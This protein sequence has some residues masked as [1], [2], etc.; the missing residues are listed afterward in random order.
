MYFEKD[1]RYTV[2]YTLQDGT[3]F[4]GGKGYVMK[5]DIGLEVVT[6]YGVSKEERQNEETYLNN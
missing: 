6:K 3:V 1:G 4:T 5:G 2:K